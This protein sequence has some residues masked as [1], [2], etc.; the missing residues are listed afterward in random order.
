MHKLWLDDTRE[1][2]DNTWERVNTW[3]CPSCRSI[4]TLIELS[5]RPVTSA[6]YAVLAAM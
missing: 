3:T 1:V 5:G 2:P 6:R 4:N